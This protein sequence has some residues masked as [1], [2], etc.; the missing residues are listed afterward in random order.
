MI[1]GTLE[2]HAEKLDVYNANLERLTVTVEEHVRRTNLL[3][4]QLK[5]IKAHVDFINTLAKLVTVGAAFLVALK[6]LG[7]LSSMG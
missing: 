1:V 4:S 3:E 6:S 5:P 2:R 7:I